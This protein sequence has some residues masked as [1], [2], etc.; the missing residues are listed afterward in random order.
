MSCLLRFDKSN[1]QRFRDYIENPKKELPD[2]PQFNFPS[3]QGQIL[4]GSYVNGHIDV[5]VWYLK[6][7]VHKIASIVHS[8]TKKEEILCIAHLVHFLGYE[9]FIN[10]FY[11]SKPRTIFLVAVKF[12][13]M[14]PNL[15]SIHK[16]DFPSIILEHKIDN[17]HVKPPIVYRTYTDIIIN[18]N[19]H[20][21]D[22]LQSP[23]HNGISNW[24]YLCKVHKLNP[25]IVQLNCI[26]EEL[27]YKYQSG[28]SIEKLVV[29][30]DALLGYNN[31]I[32]LFNAIVVLMNTLTSLRTLQEL[33]QDPYLSTLPINLLD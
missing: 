13:K 4:S 15:K 1:I 10:R 26:D 33:E 28:Y 27:R 16:S 5:L 9:D 18:C 11:L 22:Y 21:N 24:V 19:N 17:A 23:F 2:Y 3:P 8:K 7:Y 32:D 14:Y 25:N 31:H 29:K 20:F 12:Q 6:K 30:L